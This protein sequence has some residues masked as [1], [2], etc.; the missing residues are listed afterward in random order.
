MQSYVEKRSNARNINENA[1]T[2]SDRRPK[3]RQIGGEG[4]KSVALDYKIDN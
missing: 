2:C 1:P 4:S 3:R